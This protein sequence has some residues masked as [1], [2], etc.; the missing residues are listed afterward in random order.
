MVR[1][2]GV[3]AIGMSTV[4]ETLVAHHCGMEVSVQELMILFGCF[5]YNWSMFQMNQ[6][7]SATVDVKYFG[8]L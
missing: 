3:D 6:S 2:W 4:P 5:N 8:I 1:S 7:R